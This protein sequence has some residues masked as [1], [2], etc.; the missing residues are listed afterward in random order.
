MKKQPELCRIVMDK[1]D[2]VIDW[3]CK[4][5][6]FSK[7]ELSDSMTLGFVIGNNL[8]GGLVYHNIREKHDLW[9]TIYTI[10]KR[11]CTRRILKQIFGIAFDVYKVR[12]ISLLV[13]TDNQSCI[14]LVSKLGFKKEGCLRNYRENNADCYVFGM[15][16]SENLWKG[17]TNE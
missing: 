5:L 12:R 10:D 14:N 6:N 2:V 13:N 8:I 11:W 1:D 4:G 15:L 9:W 7:Q 16:K 17:K 3:V